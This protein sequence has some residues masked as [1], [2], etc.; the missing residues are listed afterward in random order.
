MVWKRLIF[1]CVLA[2]VTF[3]LGFF[4]LRRFFKVWTVYA[5]SGSHDGQVAMGIFYGSVFFAFTCAAV[6]FAFVLLRR[7]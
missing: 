5:D 4:I 3:V 6:M 1:A 2:L 7:R